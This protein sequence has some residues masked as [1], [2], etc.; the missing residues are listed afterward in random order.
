MI[1]LHKYNIINLLGI[2]GVKTTNIEEN[3]NSIIV[4]IETTPKEQIC[5]NCKTGTTKIHDYRIQKIQHIKIGKRISYLLLKK[6]RYE[7]KCCHKKFYEKYTFVEKNFRKTNDVFENIC[8]DLKQL[9]NFK[10]IAEDNNVSIP[11]VISYMKYDIFLRN[12]MT[13]KLP[14]KIGIDEFKGNCNNTKYQFH[15]FNLDTHETIDIVES[16]AYD[17]LEKY[18]SEFALEERNNVKFVSMDLYAPFKRIIQDKLFKA[19]IIADA[20]HYTRIAINPLDEIRIELWKNSAKEEKNYLKHIKRIL[21]MDS[22][23]LSEKANIRLQHAFEISPKL[24]IAYNLK[25]QFL[26]IKNK[27]TF[28]DKEKAFKQWLIDVENSNIKE[29][30][31]AINTLRTWHKYISNSFKYPISNGPVEGKNNKI[32]TIKRI[33]FGFRNLVNFKYRILCC[34]SS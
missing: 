23:K 32:K 31:S 9:K 16:R 25:E 11:T 2:Q 8:K 34:C 7:C 22:A 21:L 12:K 13:I 15:I 24:K 27:T 26:D 4:S 19:H 10:T 30:K 20:F 5:P 1:Q 6:R 28:E 17:V 18:F 3:E 14:E 33:S 29:F